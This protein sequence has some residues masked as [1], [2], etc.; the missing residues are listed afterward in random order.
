MRVL[1]A[2]ECDVPG[3]SMSTTYMGE[4]A[5]CGRDTMISVVVLPDSVGTCT[6]N[7]RTTDA[8]GTLEDE[9]TDL[10]ADQATALSLAVIGSFRFDVIDVIEIRPV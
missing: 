9:W 3:E 7:V 8:S 1:A 6:V 4:C 10:D 5:G 2:Y